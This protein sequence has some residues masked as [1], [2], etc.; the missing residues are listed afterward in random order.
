MF[1]FPY[2]KA[3]GN[4]GWMPT[5]PDEETHEQPD[6]DEWDPETMMPHW[7]SCP[8]AEKWRTRT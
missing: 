4:P 5:E 8:D 7:M 1:M 6:G 2:T 3:D